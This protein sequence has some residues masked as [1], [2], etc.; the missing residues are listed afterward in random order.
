MITLAIETSTQR[1]SVALFRGTSLLGAEVSNDFKLHSEFVNPAIERLLTQ[2]QVTLKQIDIYACGKGPGS[3]T[4]V[5]VATNVARTFAYAFGK[6]I[7]AVDSMSLLAASLNTKMQNTT[8]VPILN[9]YKNMVYCAAIKNGE[10]LFEPTAVKVTDL[11]QY[12]RDKAVT[13]FSI[14][15]DGLKAYAAFFAKSEFQ[16]IPKMSED[17]FYPK[18]ENLMD[19]GLDFLNKHQTQD[20]KL[21]EPLYIRASEAEE[22]LRTT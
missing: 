11:I 9:A 5:R 15:G 4:G 13:E 14:C 17:Y 12:C 22:N 21:I 1:A 6:P 8:V 7:V 20:W 3:F 18:A 16:N 19:L 2:N 10:F